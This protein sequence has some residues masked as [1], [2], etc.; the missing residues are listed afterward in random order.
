M[1]PPHRTDRIFLQH[2]C[3]RVNYDTNL[4]LAKINTHVFEHGDAKSNIFNFD[5]NTLSRYYKIMRHD[6]KLILKSGQLYNVSSKCVSHHVDHVIPD[7]AINHD[8]KPPTSSV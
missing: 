8:P 1:I 4:E 2:L 3:K 7:D 5:A 6:E